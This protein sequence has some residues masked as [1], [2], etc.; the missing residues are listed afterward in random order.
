MLTYGA[1]FQYL[2]VPAN[3]TGGN[4]EVRDSEQHAGKW[5][6]PRLRQGH[7]KVDSIIRTIKLLF[8]YIFVV[9][10]FNVT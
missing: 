1:T 3:V 6:Y 9:E 4:G 10:I 2:L 8:F 5:A 7:M